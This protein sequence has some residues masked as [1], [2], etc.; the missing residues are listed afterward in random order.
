MRWID[1]LGQGQRVVVVAALGAGFLTV[2]SYIQHLGDRGFA[3]GW[4]GYPPA[5][6][7]N[8][9]W[10]GWVHLVVWLAL[11]CLWAAVSI[12]LLRPSRQSNA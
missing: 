4:T 2:G 6:V 5:S 12:W 8:A 3:F 10:P 1:K 11:T 7:P 9:G